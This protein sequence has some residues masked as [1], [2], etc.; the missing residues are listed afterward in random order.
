MAVSG[1]TMP[2]VEAIAFST[3]KQL[4]GRLKEIQK[5]AAGLPEPDRTIVYEMT[6]AALQEITDC[7]E[8]DLLDYKRYLQ[9]RGKS[10]R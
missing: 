10:G 2:F 4:T 5:R 9:K 6:A 3:K 1:E 7:R 8:S